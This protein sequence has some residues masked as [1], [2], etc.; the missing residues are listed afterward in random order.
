MTSTPRWNL[1]EL[2]AAQAQPHL[3]VNQSFED[4]DI[5]LGTI[6]AISITNT[7][8]GSPAAGDT[9]IAGTSPTG[10][11]SGT[12]NRIK[13]WNGTS[14]REFIA[15]K[16]TLAY[17]DSGPKFYYWNGTAWTVTGLI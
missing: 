12:A 13:Y 9:Y 14:W 3:T 7:P 5:L 6:T 11:W 4:I 15:R 17:V 10:A 16:G 1:T 8:P 2:A